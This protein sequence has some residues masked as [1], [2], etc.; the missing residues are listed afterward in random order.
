MDNAIKA[1]CRNGEILMNIHE[2]GIE[3]IDYGCGL[4][5][6]SAD[7]KEYAEGF[8]F[9]LHI[10]REIASAHGWIVKIE[11]HDSRGV[12]AQILFNES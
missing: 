1:S 2:K 4:K 10:V 6:T 11:N 3:L 12:R 8:G 7:Q 5:K 9:G